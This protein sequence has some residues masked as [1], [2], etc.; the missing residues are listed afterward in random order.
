MRREFH[1]RFSEGAG[2]RFPRATRPVIVCTSEQDAERILTA[3]PKRF[4]RFGLTLH[5]DKTRL[6]RFVRPAQPP[7]PPRNLPPAGPGGPSSFDFL[8]FTFH[9]A[10]SRTGRWVVTR[11]TAK[12]RL[13]RAIKRVSTWCREHRHEPVTQQHQ[14]LCRAV[15][16]HYAYYA[17]TGNSR[18]IGRFVRK[19]EEAWHKWL[20]RRSNSV[21]DYWSRFAKI[22]QRFP[23]PPP[24]IVHKL[25]GLHTQ[26]MRT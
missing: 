6:V 19:V 23:L 18:Q 10:R 16:G 15:Q 12:D 2:V 17:V 25:R 24:R 22:Q 7:T 13:A 4:G 3:L 1:V 20:A 14:A 11:K 8:G 9:W 5:P 21:R 26:P